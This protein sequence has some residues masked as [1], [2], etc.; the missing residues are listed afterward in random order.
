MAVFDAFVQADGSTTR[1]YGGSGLGLSITSRLVAL[2]GGR[3][4][5]ESE[6]GRGSTFHFTLPLDAADRGVSPG[7]IDLTGLLQRAGGDRALAV[8]LVGLFEESVQ[9]LLRDL[10]QA[11]AK[12]MAEAIVRAAHTLRGSALNLGAVRLVELAREL[13]EA[14]ER[15]DLASAENLVC[16]LER[17]LS[18]LTPV[19]RA[20][21]EQGA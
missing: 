20:F 17:T 19:L 10:R 7:E 13:E 1:R 18:G 9:V 16:E 2:M 21:R 4:W 6:E 5:L 12:G 3:I 11:I 8:E 14:G 15:R